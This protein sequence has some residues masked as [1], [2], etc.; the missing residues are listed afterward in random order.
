MRV[1]RARR[2]MRRVM[3]LRVGLGRIV[4]H[5]F[6]DNLRYYQDRYTLKVKEVFLQ[7]ASCM[8]MGIR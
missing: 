5:G 1:Y 8:R 4:S 2:G 3:R 7:V 6:Y